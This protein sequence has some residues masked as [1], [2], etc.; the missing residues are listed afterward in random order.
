[1]ANYKVDFD[2]VEDAQAQ[3]ISIS[4]GL[5][6]TLDGLRSDLDKIEWD[7]AAYEAYQEHL[8]K[9]D[10][11]VRDMNAILRKIG[12]TVGSALEDTRNTD[13]EIKGRWSQ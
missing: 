6:S 11:A 7:G 10:S 9:W 1:M 3:I 2:V 4:E 13:E 5:D 8:Q 12:E